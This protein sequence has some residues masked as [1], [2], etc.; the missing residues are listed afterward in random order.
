MHVLTQQDIH[1]GEYDLEDVVLPLL[2]TSTVF[3]SNSVADK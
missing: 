2:G 3:P 1:T